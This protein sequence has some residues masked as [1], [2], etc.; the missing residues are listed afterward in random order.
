MLT[1]DREKTL[2]MITQIGS[3]LLESLLAKQVILSS[4]PSSMDTTFSDLLSK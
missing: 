3:N 2:P 4:V 1:V